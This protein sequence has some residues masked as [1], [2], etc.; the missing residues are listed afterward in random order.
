MILLKRNVFKYAYLVIV[1]YT[2]LT[3]VPLDK[4]GGPCNRGLVYIV[5]GPFILFISLMQFQAYRRLSN[6]QNEKKFFYQFISMFCCVIW[7]MFFY[8]FASDEII[9]AIVY[10]TPFLLLNIIC[11]AITINPKIIT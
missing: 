11:L 6:N 10:Y 1:V 8:L 3:L 7:S 5:L 4:T 9:K 2:L